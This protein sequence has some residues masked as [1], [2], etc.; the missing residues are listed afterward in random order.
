V[1]VVSRR[2]MASRCARAAEFLLSVI[3]CL[4]E[5]SPLLILPSSQRWT[6][7]RFPQKIK[8][9]TTLKVFTGQIVA[10]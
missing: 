7:Q 6:E 3:V 2:Y 4:A 5:F 8:G 1:S 9:E 10:Y